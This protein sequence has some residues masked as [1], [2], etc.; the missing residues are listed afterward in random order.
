MRRRSGNLRRVNIAIGA[1]LLVTGIAGGFLLTFWFLV[2]LLPIV[3]VSASWMMAWT[4]Q[5]TRELHAVAAVIITA[6][7][8][9]WLCY[10]FQYGAEM[11]T[12]YG[13]FLMWTLLIAQTALY[14]SAKRSE[15][16]SAGA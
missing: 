12:W 2:V 13:I 4:T 14:L 16:D 1:I 10:F 5:R 6:V 9:A 15:S 7:F 8:L 11:F 3:C